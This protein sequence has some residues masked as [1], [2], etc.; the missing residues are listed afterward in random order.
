MGLAPLFLFKNKT[1]WGDTPTSPTRATAARSVLKSHFYQKGA[2][3]HTAAP[4]C[5]RSAAKQPIQVVVPTQ[6][7]Q[8]STRRTATR[9]GTGFIAQNNIE[10]YSVIIFSLLSSNFSPNDIA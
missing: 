4:A 6:P 9:N 3:A 7:P 5:F 10:C 2:E 8:S 1:W